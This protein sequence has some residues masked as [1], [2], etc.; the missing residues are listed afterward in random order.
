M[1]NNSNSKNSQK[2]KQASSLQTGNRMTETRELSMAA[3]IEQDVVI[4]KSHLLS[5]TGNPDPTM[6]NKLTLSSIVQAKKLTQ[7]TEQP[8]KPVHVS[9]HT[10]QSSNKYNNSDGKSKTTAQFGVKSGDEP[11]RGPSEKSK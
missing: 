11:E 9:Q 7:S 6:K 8:F 4:E 10:Q 2:L 3:D 5:F 1:M